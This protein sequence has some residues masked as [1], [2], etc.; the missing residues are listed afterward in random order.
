MKRTAKMKPSLRPLF[1]WAAEGRP[2]PLHPRLPPTTEVLL[3]KLLFEDTIWKL[4]RA[5]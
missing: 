1:W 4:R 5:G 3:E 2:S